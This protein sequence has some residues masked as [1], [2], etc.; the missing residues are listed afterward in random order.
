MA[1]KFKGTVAIQTKGKNS[2]EKRAINTEL[3]AGLVIEYS[4]DIKKM[5]AM[6]KSMKSLLLR[7]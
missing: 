5:Q 4:M 2:A 7:V 1:K 3:L 6:E